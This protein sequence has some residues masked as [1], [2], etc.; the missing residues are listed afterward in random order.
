MARRVR[1]SSFDGLDHYLKQFLTAVFELVIESVD[2]S[3]S[4]DRYD[5]TDQAERAKAKPMVE[6]SVEP[7]RQETAIALAAEVVNED[8]A[9]VE[10][11]DLPK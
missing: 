7:R 10:V 8:A 2:V 1:I 11:P 6:A 9:S 5:Y 3:D 4:N